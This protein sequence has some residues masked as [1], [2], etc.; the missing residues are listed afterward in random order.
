M[1]QWSTRPLGDISQHYGYVFAFTDMSFEIQFGV[2]S[3]SSKTSLSIVV[4]V[5]KQHG[6]EYKYVGCARKQAS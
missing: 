4:L 6:Q 2:R 1:Q 3:E 5:G